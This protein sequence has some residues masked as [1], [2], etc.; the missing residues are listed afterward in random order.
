MTLPFMPYG[1]SL[2]CL[3]CRATYDGRYPACP[4]C[5]SRASINTATVR[6]AVL[7]VEVGKAKKKVRRPE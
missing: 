2:T 4:V 6:S 7:V 5:T 1:E 3:D